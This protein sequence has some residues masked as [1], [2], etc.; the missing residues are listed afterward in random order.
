MEF[1]VIDGNAIYAALSSAIE[2]IGGVEQQLTPHVPI[3]EEIY[4]SDDKEFK[5][6]RIKH[7]RK[8]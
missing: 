7:C 2:A 8:S 3:D 4:E 6:H 5:R 1:L